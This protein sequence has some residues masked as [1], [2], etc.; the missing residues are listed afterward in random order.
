MCGGINMS[1]FCQLPSQAIS[2]NKKTKE[3]RKKHL[4]FADSKSF[5]NYSLVRKSVIHKKINYDLLQGKLHMSDLEFILNPD[6]LSAGFIPDRIQHYSIINSKLNVLRGE[7]SKRVFDF[8][9]V[10]TNPNAITEIENNKKQE[11]L[12]KLQ[13]WVSNTSQSEEEANQELEKINDYYSYEW[14]DMREIRAN[15]LLNHY[16]KEL[17]IPLIF[18]Q[19]FM[20][21]MA[22]GEEIYQCDIVG[23]EPTIERLNPLK[24]RIFKSGYSNKIEDADMIILEDYWSPGKVIDTYYDVL[25]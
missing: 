25:T 10:V 22:V 3:W 21:A 4:D 9:V 1:E 24:V 18:N 19:G 16:V 14:Q 17:N 12:Q 11:L 2:F 8:K 23:G 6:H 20:D 13:E 5:F 7:E 15:A